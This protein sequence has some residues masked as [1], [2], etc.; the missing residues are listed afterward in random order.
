MRKLKRELPTKGRRTHFFEDC[1]RDR[2]V[3][4]SRERETSF[5]GLFYQRTRNLIVLTSA[6]NS[7]RCNRQIE[8]LVVSR[9]VEGGITN[10]DVGS[11][12]YPENC[13]FETAFF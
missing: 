11:Y 5:F 8:C 9:I 3:D 4:R 7:E 1:E 6:R 2:V 12:R 10:R 13:E